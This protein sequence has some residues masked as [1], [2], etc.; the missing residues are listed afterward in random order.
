[1]CFQTTAVIAPGEY[2]IDPWL[3][4][5]AQFHLVTHCTLMLH[6]ACVRQGD[7][8]NHPVTHH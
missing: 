5:P 1:L 8:L 4:P 6:I 3:S 7:R 2:C